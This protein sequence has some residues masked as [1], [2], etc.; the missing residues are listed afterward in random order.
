[1]QNVKRRRV[2][3]G[4]KK[5]I[6][7]VETELTETYK[8]TIEELKAK[9]TRLL[10]ENGELKSQIKAGTKSPVKEK[11]IDEGKGLKDVATPPVALCKEEEK[12]GSAH[13]V[14]DTEKVFTYRGINR[15]LD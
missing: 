14:T 15:L 11:L 10:N 13:K 3:F 5:Y 9:C 4:S 8:N 2:E 1:M 12:K 6:D 7:R